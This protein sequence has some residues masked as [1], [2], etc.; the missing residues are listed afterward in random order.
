MGLFDDIADVATGAKEKTDTHSYRS[1]QAKKYDA[2]KS[3][4]EQQKNQANQNFQKVDNYFKEAETG[5]YK[6]EG[7]Q[8][9]DQV[10]AALPDP[11]IPE[12][13]EETIIEKTIDKVKNIFTG[14]EIQQLTPEQLQR[15]QQIL[16]EYQHLDVGLLRSLILSRTSPLDKFL[17][18]KDMTYT[19]MQGNI[20]DPNDVKTMVGP[21]GKEIL[22]GP[23]NQP[24]RLSKEGTMDLIGRDTLK[25]L[26]K[27]NPEW[28]YPFMGAPGTT[29]G[30]EDLSKNQTI[31]TRDIEEK[32]A[33]QGLSF[34]Q[35][36][37]SEEYKQA[38]KYNQMIFDARETVSR[39]RDDR[40]ANRGLPSLPQVQ[41]TD[42]PMEDDMNIT[43]TPTPDPTDPP[44]IP[45]ILPTPSPIFAP[46]PH[47]YSQ[48][49]QFGP[50]YPG[51]ATY[52]PAGG[53]IPNYV[54]QG[55]GSAPQFN[56]WNQIANTFPGM[57]P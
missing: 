22:V 55:L 17:G 2:E 57:R 41:Y 56:Y 46:T 28:Y 24:V 23:D 38:T 54:N 33:A 37:N 44:G 6:Q 11:I 8:T 9:Q 48:W 14:P 53:P 47:D 7:A 20:I 39:D 5:K 49:P 3:G 1:A 12:V 19:D 51:Y 32:L 10:V 13:D 50:Q 26:Q 43:P 52:G 45:G 16:R 21:D 34:D 4:N 42:I 25:S 40:R 30:L 36:R 35:I 29:G 31:N 15:A 27:F 18:G